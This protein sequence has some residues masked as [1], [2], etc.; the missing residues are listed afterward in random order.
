MSFDYDLFVIGAGS[1]G[2]RASRMSTGQG[3]KVGI[4]EESRIGG[5]CVIRGCV[6]KKLLVFA[7]KFAEAFEDAEGF[8]WSVGPRDFSW[9]KLI[10]NKDKEIDR[11][12][13]AYISLL[14]NAKV[15]IHPSRATFLDPH[16][17]KVGEK[18]LTAKNILI[19]TGG[20][21]TLP[22][23]PGIEHAISSDEAFHLPDL[24]KRI[25]V[26]G[27]GYIAVEFAGIFKGLGAETTIIHRGAKLLRGFDED[28]RDFLPIEMQKKGMGL[29]F[30]T[31]VKRI[32]KVADGSLVLYFE[33]GDS[34]V[35]DAVMFA[36]G[37]NPNTRGLGLEKAG[38]AVAE[39]GAIPVDQYS[40]TNVAHIHAIGDV[41]DRLQLTPVAIKEAMAFVATVF[42]GRPTPAD[43]K[44]VP[45][46]VFSQ[47]E[48]GTVGLTEMEAANAFGAL[49]IY[50]TDFK[51]M[52]HTMTGRSERTFMK[53]V[54]DRASQR[55]VGAHMVGPDAGEIIQGL[56]IAVKMGATK[57]QFDATVG[58]HPT[59]AEEFVTM[60][61]AW[62]PPAAQA[63]E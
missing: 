16:T 14:K 10:A 53:L 57:Q 35:V 18:T 38:V 21:P 19:A 6:P 63:A 39:S 3:A 49:D 60:R 51:P 9:P 32:V 31:D 50:K 40:A 5:T 11:L 27:G 36:T 4:A 30:N 45:T 2:V 42:G 29:R 26:V 1:G 52:K 55:V 44:D 47:P 15:E 41:T 7:S 37:R 58:I 59:A 34:L 25:A 24:P 54:V 56:G 12:N 23:I 33:G 61:E 22:A 62:K 8:G 46:A 20:R 43:H 13:K 17:L 48:I 28:L